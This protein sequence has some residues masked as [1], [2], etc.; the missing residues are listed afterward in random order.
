MSINWPDITS[1][2]LNAAVASDVVNTPLMELSQRTQYLYDRFGDVDAEDGD[3][4]LKAILLRDVSIGDNVSVGTVVYFDPNGNCWRPALAD[5]VHTEAASQLFESSFASGIIVTANANTGTVLFSGE[6][7]LSSGSVL[8][9][10]GEAFRPGPYWLSA[11][12]AGRLTQYK[13]DVAVFVGSFFSTRAV[14][15]FQHRDM[16]EAHNHVAIAMHSKASG[17]LVGTYLTGYQPDGKHECR[18]TLC[19]AGS[20]KGQAYTYVV[21][22]SG[23]SL[24]WESTDPE[25][26]GLP[27]LSRTI[28]GYTAGTTYG[29]GNK[30]V[31]IWLNDAQVGN[32]LAADDVWT[33]DLPS[34]GLG[35]TLRDPDFVDEEYPDAKLEYNIGYHES[36]NQIYPPV[37][38]RA[39]ALM[40]NGVELASDALFSEV[41]TSVYAATARTLYWVVDDNERFPWPDGEEAYQAKQ[42]VFH[43]TKGSSGSSGSVTSLRPAPNSPLRVYAAGTSTPA[44]SG[45][46][47]LGLQLALETA[48]S[49]AMG[50]LVVKKTE[51]NLLKRGAVVERIESASDDIVVT[52]YEG[53]PEGQ[54]R[55]VLSSSATAL[56]GAFDIV[57]L[58]NAKQD[59][60]GF[61]P[62][63]RILGKNTGI[64][65]GFTATFQVPYN[66]PK[67]RKYR[68]IVY[69]TVFGTR[70]IDIGTRSVGLKFSFSILPDYVGDI[71]ES[72]GNLMN[73]TI[74]ETMTAVLNLGRANAPYSAYDPVLIHNDSGLEDNE[75]VCSRILGN[76]FPVSSHLKPGFSVGVKFEGDTVTNFDGQYT[77]D[78][79][80]LNLRWK[81]LPVTE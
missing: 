47:E 4:T 44:S 15:S 18:F 24:V 45:D 67:D 32:N 70:D 72:P 36:F 71:P 5:A 59:K 54:G 13:P 56:A 76:P 66:L 62:Y 30:G 11:R 39:S 16:A 37:P 73:A 19:L 79:G 33:L 38:L 74:N 17:T 31:K 78:L 28:A 49:D 26:S 1:I 50:Y 77:G 48:G 29:I 27:I 3:V 81:I 35:W 20:Y 75:M 42:M 68:A 41:G 40:L 55:I 60:I 8:L 52:Q 2:P 23:T 51:G 69:A 22:V 80:F 64:A 14:V 12:Q 7:N 53:D 58:E 9:Q 65:S 25:L 57:A 6:Y 21:K 43:M 10:D 63:I 46:L 34:A 61:F